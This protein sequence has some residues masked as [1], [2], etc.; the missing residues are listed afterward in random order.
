MYDPYSPYGEVGTNNDWYGRGL[1]QETMDK[2]TKREITLVSGVLGIGVLLFLLLGEGLGLLVRAAYASGAVDR[3][4]NV[5]CMFQCAYTIV[6]ILVPFTLAALVV[7]RIEK[8]DELMPMGPPKSPS[9]FW[10]SLAVG[11]MAA[12]LCN[13][14]NSWLNVALGQHGVSFDANPV[15]YPETVSNWIWILLCSA[16][17]PAL[18]EEFA[19][20][21]VIMQSLRK[22]GDGLALGMSA[23]LF[24][25]MHGNMTQAPFAFLLGLVIGRLVI[26]TNSIWTGIAIHCL[27]NVYSV[28]MSTVQ[29]NL[30]NMVTAEAVIIIMTIA[31][32][33]GLCALVWMAGMYHWKEKEPLHRR[34][35]TDHKSRALWSHQALLYTIISL[36]MAAALI[37]LL[38]KLIGTIHVQ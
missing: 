29:Y 26:A 2:G 23:L 32:I 10:A 27:N 1:T 5:E 38:V 18:C 3:T 15:T 28:V 8:K 37:W 21:G 12:L 35:G 4:F 7:K 13:G 30:G 22:Y 17:L 20:R 25:M 33:A 9:L 11:F 19:L 14:V 24:A 36:P 6:A 34:G 16:I 31:F